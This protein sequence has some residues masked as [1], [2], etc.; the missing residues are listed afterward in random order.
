MLLNCILQH[1]TEDSHSNHSSSVTQQ[2]LHTQ[3]QEDAT[4][5][6]SNNNNLADTVVVPSSLSISREGEED[7]VENCYLVEGTNATN[8]NNGT[9][10]TTSATTTP[11]HLIL[12]LQQL[13]TASN[14]YTLDDHSSLLQ[15][16]CDDETNHHQYY[17]N[18]ECVTTVWGRIMN[19][20]TRHTT[21]AAG[22]NLSSRSSRSPFIVKPSNMMVMSECEDVGVNN[23]NATVHNNHCNS[24]ESSSSSLLCKT[25]N[26]LSSASAADDYSASPLHLAQSFHSTCCCSTNNNNEH[27]SSSIIIPTIKLDEFVMPGSELQKAMSDAILKLSPHHDVS[28]IDDSEDECVICME[29]F[30]DDNPRMPT[31]CRCGENKTYFHLPCL[32]L[33]TDKNGEC[34]SCRQ[35]ITWEEF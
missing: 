32:L 20:V 3:Q 29:G 31:L 24:N 5:N 6:L 4:A 10:T 9:T 28:K 17:R 19:V 2:H 25:S 18:D 34:P 35:H 23:V 21:A 1:C 13:S 15:N 27:D 12:Q 16:D 14:S 30:N 26:T 22:S 11:H 7:F 33:W 8:D